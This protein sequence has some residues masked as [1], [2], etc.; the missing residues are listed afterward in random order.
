M[1]DHIRH[2]RRMEQRWAALDNS[3]TNQKKTI[4]INKQEEDKRATETRETTEAKL[5]GLEKKLDEVTRRQ[6]AAT[7]PAAGQ[8]TQPQQQGDGQQRMAAEWL[9]IIGGFRQDTPGEL[10]VQATWVFPKRMRVSNGLMHMPADETTQPPIPGTGGRFEDDCWCRPP[11]CW[12]HVVMSIFRPWSA[13]EL[14][15][16]K[17]DH[18]NGKCNSKGNNSY[19]MRL[20]RRR[21]RN[22]R[23]TGR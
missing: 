13:A 5:K 18:R 19:S 4:T 23:G 17:F 7:T 6:G 12:P 1:E 11:I 3:V 21:C 9:V 16:D 20:G 15:F 14:L 2:I 10:M 22:D 8:S